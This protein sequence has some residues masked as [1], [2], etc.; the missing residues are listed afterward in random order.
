MRH[1][2][3][4]ALSFSIILAAC[5][6]IRLL[7]F[8]LPALLLIA[9]GA[10]LT[11]FAQ[12]SGTITGTVHDPQGAVVPKASITTAHIGTGASR[13]VISDSAGGYV[14]PLLPIG[15]YQVT[16]ESRG[17]KKSAAR[18]ILEAQQTARVDFAL[19]LGTVAVETTVQADAPILKAD[20]SDIGTVVD[21]QRMVDLPMNGRN[22]IA[23]NA[24]DAGAATQTGSRTSYFVQLFGGNYSFNGSGGDS[25]TYSIDGI[26]AK[27]MGDARVTLQLSIDTIQ[28]FNQQT[29]LYSAEFSGGGGNV[30]V[31]R[32]E[33]LRSAGR[34]CV[35]ALRK[36]KNRNPHRIWHFL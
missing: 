6:R 21:N 9:L 25:S 31:V 29:S 10:S 19:E 2:F 28:E 15:E 24:L 12:T 14:V 36:S 35:S 22:F 18:V 20:T 1:A 7:G 26:V 16:V 13:S 33:K 11:I 32:R 4:T 3:A 23:L 34:A 5:H 30:N 17:F 27:G 8:R